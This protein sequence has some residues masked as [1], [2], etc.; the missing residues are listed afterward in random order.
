MTSEQL[1]THWA[2]DERQL[3][4]GVHETS[5]EV[6]DRLRNLRGLTR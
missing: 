3:E 4:A 1:V 5:P 2:T 6:E